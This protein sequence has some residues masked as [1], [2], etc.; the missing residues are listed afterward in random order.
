MDYRDSEGYFLEDVLQVLGRP[1]NSQFSETVLG[2]PVYGRLRDSN[3]VEESEEEGSWTDADVS[4]SDDD[5]GDDSGEEE[6]EEAKRVLYLSVV[7]VLL[8]MT[9]RYIGR[10]LMFSVW[11][12]LLTSYFEH[13]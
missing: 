3:F 4:V 8:P 7:G 9:F 5:D 12:R 10:R 13:K 1:N 6:W 11:T 2:S